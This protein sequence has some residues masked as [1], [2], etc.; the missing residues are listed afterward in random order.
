M[1]RERRSDITTEIVQY[2]ELAP[3]I[4]HCCEYDVKTKMASL[5]GGPCRVSLCDCST[6]AAPLRTAG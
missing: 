4:Y 1:I 5:R 3:H 2:V 6:F